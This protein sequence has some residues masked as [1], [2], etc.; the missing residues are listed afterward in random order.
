MEPYEI[1]KY[2]DKRLFI[3]SVD[4]K[5]TEFKS[6][7]LINIIDRMFFTMKINEGIGLAAP[8]VNIHK[9]IVV[10]EIENKKLV[11]INPKITYKSE[12][13]TTL[14]EGCLSV[15]YV[16]GNVLRP[17]DI[18]VSF[19]DINGNN[20]HLSCSGLLSKCIQ[21]EIDHL[22]GILY[23]NR[24]NGIKKQILLKKYEK[25]NKWK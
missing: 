15:P 6:N 25:I 13:K 1:L 7:D 23:I 20:S 18:E 4:V 24:I 5:D 16:S 17:R 9:N 19:Y 2:P 12:E 11:L 8:Q 14:D 22:N 10:M 21:H 3:E